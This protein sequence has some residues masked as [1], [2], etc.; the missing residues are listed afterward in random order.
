MEGPDWRTL[1]T[2]P[3]PPV[4]QYDLIIGDDGTIVFENVQFFGVP[5]EP[6]MASA[7]LTV[8]R[9]PLFEHRQPVPEHIRAVKLTADNIRTV[10][11]HILEQLGGGVKV[12]TPEDAFPAGIYRENASGAPELIASQGDW[13]LEKYDYVKGTPVYVKASIADKQKY[14]LR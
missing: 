13:L 8:D 14:D 3:A 10:A 12:E 6:D 9:G 1:M 7:T 5:K 4:P 11:A 2:A